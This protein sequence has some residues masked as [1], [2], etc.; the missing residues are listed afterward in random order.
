MVFTRISKQ[1]RI[2]AMVALFFFVWMTL[3]PWT[4]SQEH[5][6]ALY[7]D[8]EMRGLHKPKPNSGPDNNGRPSAGHER[9]DRWPELMGR[10]EEAA[11]PFDEKRGMSFTAKLKIDSLMRDMRDEYESLEKELAD[12]RKSLIDMR[13]PKEF[14]DRQDEF[15][16]RVKEKYSEA[17]LGV[18]DL[19]S[20]DG[21][22]RG[23][24]KL[25][26][27]RL[28]DASK[29][30]R[31]APL[32]P[33]EMPSRRVTEKDITQKSPRSGGSKLGSLIQ[34]EP[35]LLA[36]AGDTA[37]LLDAGNGEFMVASSRIYDTPDSAD[38]TSTQETAATE[39]II[40][41][42]Q[43]LACDPAR[44]YNWVY[45]N[46]DF[47]PYFGS[48]KGANETLWQREGNDMDQASLL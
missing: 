38:L 36:S 7:A 2:P 44:M 33:E 43:E 4:Y 30:K 34:N 13:A 42:T 12:T 19:K 32:N 40:A 24:G 14:L 47:V 23:A 20:R 22:R 11:E 48:L 15:E 35:L 21:A 46:I 28:L 26:I 3:E 1:L 31:L 18:V 41:L 6:D 10:L 39:D 25:R 16:K 5:Q 27:K 37:G 17:K 8:A 29:P 45:N 9:P